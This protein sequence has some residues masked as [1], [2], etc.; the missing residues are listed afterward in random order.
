MATSRVR[1]R[2][3]RRVLRGPGGQI[4]ALAAVPARGVCSGCYRRPEVR[5]G[6]A[7]SRFAP[8]E[9]ADFNGPGGRPTPTDALPGTEDKILALQERAQAGQELFCRGDRGRA[10]T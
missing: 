7:P 5:G 9:V 6:F 4:A 2:S 1:V 8:A 3:G 10:L